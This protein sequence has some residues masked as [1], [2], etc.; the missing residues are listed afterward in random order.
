MPTV[1]S[2]LAFELAQV[3]LQST[4]TQLIQGYTRNR[5]NIKRVIVITLLITVVDS[6]RRIVRD[7]RNPPK[8]NKEKEKEK[9]QKV[10]VS[11]LFCFVYS[12]HGARNKEYLSGRGK[13]KKKKSIHSH[14]S[15]T[16]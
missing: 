2:K 8:R 12:I 13:K 15:T 11:T 4:L 3:H 14:P 5:K 16:E 1:H 6:I 10:E 7:V 9:S